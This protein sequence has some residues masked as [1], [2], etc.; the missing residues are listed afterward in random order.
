MLFRRD[1]NPWIITCEEEMDF[2]NVVYTAAR[3]GKLRRLKTSLP[4]GKKS[5]DL[6]A[7]RMFFCPAAGIA[8]VTRD[9]AK[10]QLVT[11]TSSVLLAEINLGS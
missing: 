1:F 7:A 6:I 9:S 10:V 4:K 2:K 3:D 11:P 5:V 8:R